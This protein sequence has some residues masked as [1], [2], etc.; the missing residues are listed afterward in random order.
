MLPFSDQISHDPVL[1][2][3]LKIPS[4]QSH[5]LG[6]AEATPEQ[7]R[8]DSPIPLTADA[9]DGEHLQQLSRLFDCQ[10][11]SDPSAQPFG[12]L[13]TSDAG[14]ESE[15]S[16]PVSAASYAR[17]RTAATRTLIVD[18]ARFFCSRKNRYRSTTVRLKASLG[19]EQYQPMNSSIACPYDS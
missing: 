13:D 4:L 11:V 17:L 19:S 2:A 1:L 6:T 10:P 16:I 12:T 9:L 7:K 18:G 5:E 14:G 15:L 3:K 8:N